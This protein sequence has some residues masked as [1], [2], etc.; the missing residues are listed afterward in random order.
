MIFFIPGC[1]AR[2]SYHRRKAL[3]LVRLSH[4]IARLMYCTIAA[5]PSHAK[6]YFALKLDLRLDLDS[7]NPSLDL[8]EVGL[9][10]ELLKFDLS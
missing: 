9:G 8:N 6:S 10:L 1:K 2:V 5:G 7:L 3:L 4:E